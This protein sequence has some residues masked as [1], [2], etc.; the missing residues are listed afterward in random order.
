MGYSNQIKR[1]A[2]KYYDEVQDKTKTAKKYK[3]RYNTVCSWIK[4][5]NKI[6]M[7]N[8]LDEIENKIENIKKR[9]SK[10]AEQNIAEICRPIVEELVDH[11]EIRRITNKILKEGYSDEMLD[12]MIS[13]KA[14]GELTRLFK[15]TTDVLFRANEIANR[16]GVLIEETYKPENDNLKNA[17]IDGLGNNEN[18]DDLICGD[19]YVQET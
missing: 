19:S 12:E 5:R 2:L 15:T 3:V 13:A 9:V 4:N 8:K 10:T 17:I 6:E 1:N 11:Y 18:F 7:T 14:V 16:T